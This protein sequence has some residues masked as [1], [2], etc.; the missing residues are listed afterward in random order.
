MPTHKTRNTFYPFV[1]PRNQA[2]PLE[3]EFLKQATYIRHV[4][5]K[6]SKFFQTSIQASSDSFLQRIL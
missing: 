3:N 5:V 2:R 6:L 4:I 1:F